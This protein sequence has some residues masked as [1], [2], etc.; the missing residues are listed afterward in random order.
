MVF[1]DAFIES[2]RFQMACKV[3]SQ[4]AAP[5]LVRLNQI[6]LSRIS[7]STLGSLV[8][9]SNDFVAYPSENDLVK[10]SAFKDI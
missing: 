9:R 5:M 4:R 6:L 10:W 1:I 7:G 3:F 2:S 8:S